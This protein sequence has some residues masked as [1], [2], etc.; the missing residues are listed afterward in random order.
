MKIYRHSVSF[1]S[2]HGHSSTGMTW[3]DIPLK[4]Q[5]WCWNDGFGHY[6]HI[7]LIPVIPDSWGKWDHS[8]FHPCHSK[9][10][11]SFGCHLE[12]LN[13]CEFPRMTSEWRKI[14]SWSGPVSLSDVQNV[15]EIF[16]FYSP[17]LFDVTFHACRGTQSTELGAAV[18]L[19]YK[20]SRPTKEYIHVKLSGTIEVENVNTNILPNSHSVWK[21]C[22]KIRC[23]Q[24]YLFKW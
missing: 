15:F 12:I 6:Q 14:L 3:N 1:H 2:F 23:T 7:P 18:Q 13:Q 4:W 10:I 11:P 5:E 19:L 21:L 24:C 16:S 9:L 20:G 8:W 22:G 17:Y